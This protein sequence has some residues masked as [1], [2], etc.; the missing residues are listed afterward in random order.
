MTFDAERRLIV[1]D[2]S[3][4]GT[5]VRYDNRYS[6]KEAQRR[7]NFTWIIGGHVALAEVKKI[8]L[9]VSPELM[10]RIVVSQPESLDGYRDKVDRFLQETESNATLSLGALDMRSDA[11]TAA[12]DATTPAP[13]T[14][15]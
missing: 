10:F 4:Y 6:K 9:E 7:R 13:Q 2:C 3:T 5:I 1:R 15:A 12:P 8:V 14:L 11:S